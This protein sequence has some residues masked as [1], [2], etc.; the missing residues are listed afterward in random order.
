[1]KFIQSSNSRT[2]YPIL[3]LKEMPDGMILDQ[4]TNL[5]EQSKEQDISQH[6]PKKGD[7]GRLPEN[8]ENKN[9]RHDEPN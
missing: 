8:N 3:G 9:N 7:T 2:P 5:M 6:I 4:F 1:M